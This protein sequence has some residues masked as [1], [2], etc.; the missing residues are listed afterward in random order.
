[1]AKGADGSWVGYECGEREG[2]WWFLFVYN[3]Y[4]NMI[5]FY[6]VSWD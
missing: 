4:N 5:L 3:Y 6:F 2:E 1:M